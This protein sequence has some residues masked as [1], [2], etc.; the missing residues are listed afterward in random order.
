MTITLAP[1]IATKTRTPV[2]NTL[3]RRVRSYEAKAMDYAIATLA[4]SST[5]SSICSGSPRTRMVLFSGGQPELTGQ[6]QLN[7]IDMALID[8]AD[9]LCFISQSEFSRSRICQGYYKHTG[10]VEFMFYLS[11]SSVSAAPGDMYWVT[12]IIGKIASEMEATFGTAGY[13]S[14][15]EVLT[16]IMPLTDPT[17]ALAGI[18]VGGITLNWSNVP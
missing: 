6:T 15:G 10:S 3:V 18:F 17:G 13:F 1:T 11:P 12:S 2:S 14:F 4:N 16:T 7:N 9:P 5:W 8:F